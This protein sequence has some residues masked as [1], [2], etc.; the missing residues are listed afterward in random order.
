MSDQKKPGFACTQ[1]PD[2]A[3]AIYFCFGEKLLGAAPRKAW[4]KCIVVASHQYHD[5][6]RKTES[7]LYWKH[8]PPIDEPN[9]LYFTR[10]RD[11]MTTLCIFCKRDGSDI[12]PR[13]RV[14][15]EPL[16]NEEFS[17]AISKI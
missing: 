8:R 12:N 15:Q 13:V 4:E 16:T 7:D 10:L 9:F 6:K 11:G 5:Y 2:F 3:D 17:N 14:C 1:K